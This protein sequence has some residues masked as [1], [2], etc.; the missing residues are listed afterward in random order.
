M[1]AVELS[2]CVDAWLLSSVGLI[3][4]FV[5]SPMNRSLPCPNGIFATL[6]GFTSIIDWTM[7][8]TGSRSGRSEIRN[9]SQRRHTFYTL[10]RRSTLF[11]HSSTTAG[12]ERDFDKNS[13]N[14]KGRKSMS[15]AYRLLASST[16]FNTNI[17]KQYPNRY[18]YLSN[19]DYLTLSLFGYMCRSVL[20]S[21]ERK[22]QVLQPTD[23]EGR[24][25]SPLQNLK[26]NGDVASTSCSASSRNRFTA[27]RF[28][29]VCLYFCD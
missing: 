27:A 4:L 16:S 5:S 1:S 19:F 28:C 7:A 11:F 29:S 26:F 18:R 6:N 17:F 13:N 25:T 21:L 12:T 24:Q 14:A 20:S 9:G 8:T 10:A 23:R 22:T 3:R 2:T 15:V